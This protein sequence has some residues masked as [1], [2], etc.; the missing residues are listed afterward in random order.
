MRDRAVRRAALVRRTPS[1]LPADRLRERVVEAIGDALGFRLSRPG[2]RRSH[3]RRVG[4]AAAGGRPAP[5]ERQ[6]ELL[7][8]GGPGAQEV[9]VVRPARRARP[10]AALRRRRPGYRT[11]R[12]ETGAGRRNVLVAGAAL[13]AAGRSRL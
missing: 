8:G 3:R 13:G 2:A 11:R 12:Q 1:L 6:Q 10:A 7:G 5:G 9:G 4:G